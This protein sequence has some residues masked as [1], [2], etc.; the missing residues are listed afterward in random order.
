METANPP[1]QQVSNFTSVPHPYCVLAT[2]SARADD[3][4]N[5]K[6]RDVSTCCRTS[7]RMTFA[8]NSRAARRQAVRC[9]PRR[10][11][12]PHRRSDEQRT[13]SAAFPMLPTKKRMCR[14]RRSARIGGLDHRLHCAISRLR[15]KLR[16]ERRVPGIG[17]SQ[18]RNPGIGCGRAAFRDWL[19]PV[20]Q[21]RWQS[22][23]S[24]GTMQ[25][26]R[27]G[28]RLQKRPAAELHIGSD[29]V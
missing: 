26:M 28:L 9:R 10:L 29:V 22:R 18:A 16:E 13:D 11:Q 12:G 27:L 4:F 2:N 6:E 14:T 24:T 8:A 15:P 25:G 19:L 3:M 1:S 21:S 23:T 20:G 7:S 17:K 5:D